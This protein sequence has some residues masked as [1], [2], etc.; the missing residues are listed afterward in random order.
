MW[1]AFEHGGL[2]RPRQPD[3][4]HRREPARPA[5]PDDARLGP[6]RLRSPRRGVRLARH[7]HRRTRRR[8]RR[9]RLRRSAVDARAPDGDPGAHRSR[10]RASGRRGPARAGTA[11]RSPIPT[12]RSPSSAASGNLTVDVPQAG[13]LRARA[14]FADAPRSSCPRYELGEQVATRKAYGDALA[15]LGD[16][17]RR[18]RRPRRRGGE[19]DLHRGVREGVSRSASSRCS[20][21]S[22][23]WSPRRSGCR[24]A[25]WK[26]FASTF[27]AFFT[28]AYDFV[29]MAAISARQHQAVRLARGRLDRRGRPVADGARGSSR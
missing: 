10:A 23:S 25:G 1:E 21:P 13:G 11:S 16:A 7:R 6:R 20:S 15:A 3:R 26:P 22:S 8:G 18:R 2:L 17:R 14:R 28:R 4:D 5:R 24:C 9:P 19:L 12:R 29:R 27:A